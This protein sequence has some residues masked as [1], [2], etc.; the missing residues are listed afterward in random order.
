MFKDKE[1]QGQLLKLKFCT[2]W[3]E[4]DMG[5]CIISRVFETET[6]YVQMS[7]AIRLSA[8]LLC[9]PASNIAF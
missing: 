4:Y 3:L 5:I 6:F 1:L 7:R 8:G 9:S 2:L